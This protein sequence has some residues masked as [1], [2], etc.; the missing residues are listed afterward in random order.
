MNSSWKSRVRDR[1]SNRQAA[2]KWDRMY[3]TQTRLLDEHNYR[4]R[5]DFAVRWLE[6]QLHLQGNVLDIGCGAGALLTELRS[7]GQAVIGVDY[8]PDMLV[9]ARDR[10]RDHGLPTDSLL[11]ADADRLPFAANA[12]DAVTCLGVISYLEEFD[13]ALGEIARVLRPGA[14]ALV[15]FRNVFNPVFSDPAQAV[16][17]AWQFVRWRKRPE[18]NGIGRFL[19]PRDVSQRLTRAGLR[20]EGFR[21]IGLGPYR[22]F[23]RR[24]LGETPSIVV[25]NAVSAVLSGVGLHGVLAWQ[26]DVAM[27]LCRKPETPDA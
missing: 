13:A 23:G 22:L 12:F 26:A 19:D 4:L 5:R 7:R 20:V 14:P 15:T 8:S 2:A 3:A 6:E 27:V 10:L 24:I 25:S 16:R 18:A 21:G 9:L 17:A 11:R 1:F